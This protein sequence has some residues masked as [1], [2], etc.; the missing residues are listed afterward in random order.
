MTAREASNSAR[1]A[2]KAGLPRRAR[3]GDPETLSAPT[4]ADAWSR[5][6]TADHTRLAELDD[7]QDEI[8]TLLLYTG[9]ADDVDAAPMF[10]ELQIERLAVYRAA[11][12]RTQHDVSPAHF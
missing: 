4:F 7:T 1:H 12:D 6:N 5:L 8:L 3:A 9:H 10:T 2:T 11:L